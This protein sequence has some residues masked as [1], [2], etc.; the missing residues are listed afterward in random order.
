MHDVLITRK[1]NCDE[2]II[3]HFATSD[4]HRE[5][6]ST[7]RELQQKGLNPCW[8]FTDVPSHNR[9]LLECIFNTLL[10]DMDPNADDEEECLLD[11][12]EP[13]LPVVGF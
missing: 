5:L 12:S 4:N 2:T 10:K 3:N 9:D 6:E 7:L 13:M 11:A 1:N 8:F